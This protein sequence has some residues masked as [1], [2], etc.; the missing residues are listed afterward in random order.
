MSNTKAVLAAVSVVAMLGFGW[1]F[2]QGTTQPST[3]S[4]TQPCSLEWRIVVSGARIGSDQEGTRIFFVTVV[5]T[6]QSDQV[7]YTPGLVGPVLWPKTPF[8]GEPLE[9]HTPPRRGRVSG[10]D[11]IT[12]RPGEGFS[13][14]SHV[15]VAEQLEAISQVG[16]KLLVYKN[17]FEGQSDH[18][19]EVIDAD[20]LSVSPAEK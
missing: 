10:K 20:R 12:L 19:V 1:C 5:N 9:A 13:R 4:S 14:A 11:F 15:L 8:K 6:G 16:G 7:L 3:S 2:A 18:V 17:G